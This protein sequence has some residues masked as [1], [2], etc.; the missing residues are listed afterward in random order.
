MSKAK[1][2]PKRDADSFGVNPLL[3]FCRGVKNDLW[4]EKKAAK[5]PIFETIIQML[6]IKN[7]S[8]QKGPKRPLQFVFDTLMK[9]LYLRP[10]A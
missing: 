7:F 8:L 10:K 6:F 4:A 9:K 3:K 5:N 2:G 1:K